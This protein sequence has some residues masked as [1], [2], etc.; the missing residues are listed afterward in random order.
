MVSDNIKAVM[1]LPPKTAKYTQLKIEKIE[2]EV[3]KARV[4]ARWHDQSEEER[5]NTDKTLDDVQE[6]ERVERQIVKGNK[7]NLNNIR[8]TELP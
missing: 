1:N 3:D 5:A 7:V 2:L 4:K 8:V 6:G